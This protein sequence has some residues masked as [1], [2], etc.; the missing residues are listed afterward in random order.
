VQDGIIKKNTAARHKAQLIKYIN[1]LKWHRG[2]RPG[3]PKMNSPV[4][5]SQWCSIPWFF[6]W[7]TLW[8]QKPWDSRFGVSGRRIL[9]W[10]PVAWVLHSDICLSEKGA[11]V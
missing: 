8:V 4:F 7:A 10:P 5:D 3:G 1:T 9:A 11:D 6:G 2:Q